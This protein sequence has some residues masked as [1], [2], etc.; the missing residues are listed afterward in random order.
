MNLN[1]GEFRTY[2]ADGE[3]IVAIKQESNLSQDGGHTFEDVQNNYALTRKDA[4]ELIRELE[5]YIREAK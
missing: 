3:F 1:N 5:S 4:M 2:I